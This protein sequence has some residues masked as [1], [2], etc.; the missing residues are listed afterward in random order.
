MK[1]FK[2]F[3][4]VYV[5]FVGVDC[6]NCESNCTPAT[7]WC[8]KCDLIFC[9]NCFNS[10]HKYKAFSGHQSIQIDQRPIDDLLC[11]EHPKEKLTYWCIT[12]EKLLCRSCYD[13]N[14]RTHKIDT[15]ED[16][17]KLKEKQ[18]RLCSKIIDDV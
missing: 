17:S 12:D 10:T 6:Q 1:L 11:A 13:I 2:D 18:V 8:E 5:S 4:I 3:M 15:I 7:L 14:H 16:A 9:T